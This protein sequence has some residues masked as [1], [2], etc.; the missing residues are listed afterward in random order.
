MLDTIVP[1]SPGTNVC[2]EKSGAAQRASF[3]LELQGIALTA[4]VSAVDTVSVRFQNGTAGTVDLGS[5]MLRARVEK[6]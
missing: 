6:A 1:V 3:S 5:G 2:P 4:W